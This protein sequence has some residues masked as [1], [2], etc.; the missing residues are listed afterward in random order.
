M[1]DGKWSHA[2]DGGDPPLRTAMIW[3]DDPQGDIRAYA[4]SQSD[5]DFFVTR[6]NASADQAA[7]IERLRADLQST[8]ASFRMFQEGYIECLAMPE[9]ERHEMMEYSTRLNNAARD[10]GLMA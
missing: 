1:S 2:E 6:L 9:S 7:E 5:A 8:Y 3:I 4:L 10:A